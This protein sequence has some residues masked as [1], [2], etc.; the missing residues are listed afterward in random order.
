[1]VNMLISAAGDKE[2]NCAFTETVANR[3]RKRKYFFV[4]I[5]LV[6]DFWFLVSGFRFKFKIQDSRFKVQD[7][8]FKVCGLEILVFVF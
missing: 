6:S 8:R 1:M 3:R 5:F 2:P 7:S 4:T